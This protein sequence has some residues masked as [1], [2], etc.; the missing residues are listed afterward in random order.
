MQDEKDDLQPV[1]HHNGT[2][3]FIAIVLFVIGIGVGYGVGKEMKNKAVTDDTVKPPPELVYDGGTHVEE[4]KEVVE[5]VPVKPADQ[6]GSALVGSSFEAKGNIAWYEQSK[7]LPDQKFF[8]FTTD[9]KPEFR[10]A[11]FGTV[12]EG[13]YKGG[14]LVYAFEQGMG[15]SYPFRFVVQTD[16]KVV[17]L[18]KHSSSIELSGEGSPTYKGIFTVDTITTFE[19]LVLPKNL[20]LENGANIAFAEFVWS[21]SPP[22]KTDIKKEYTVGKFTRIYQLTYAPGTFYVV[23]PDGIGEQYL[24]QVPVTSNKFLFTDGSKGGDYIDHQSGGCGTMSVAL[25][26]ETVELED[27]V[28]IGTVKGSGV[29]L[30]EFSD[31]DHPMLKEIYSQYEMASIKG[32]SLLYNEFL[33]AKPVVLWKSE[34]G[35]FVRFL[36]SSFIVGGECG[37]PVI[38]LY[39]E[40]TTE[41]NVKVAPKNGFSV[42]EPSYGTSGWNVTA[43]P[44]GKLVDRATGKLWPYL[45][46]EG[47]GSTVG[48]AQQKGFVVAKRDVKNLL[49]SKLTLAGLNEKE[50]ADF[51]AFWLPR[52]QTSPYYFVTFYGNTLMNE[53]APLTVTPKPESIIRIL[54]DYKPLE[55]PVTVQ[56]LEIHTPART[57]FT[58]VE[59][60]GVLH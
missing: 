51:I 9:Y 17:F 56:P 6:T 47:K 58:V 2:W 22:A 53:I 8:I 12:Q 52:M 15:E 55:K 16:G 41:V 48:T 19:D 59:W 14:R 25:L 5:E 23:T 60:G 57:G 18:K 26:D 42:T 45:F 34:F 28:K 54:M 24:Y 49:E 37:K 43:S 7:P 27:V 20:L 4:P 13:Q 44:D 30:Y 35:N 40:K 50:R 29:S 11:E 33:K 38:Y 21:H 3:I 36:N 31:P 46:W 10:Y 32:K 39:P 1:A